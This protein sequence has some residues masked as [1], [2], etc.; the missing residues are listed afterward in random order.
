MGAINSMRPFLPL[1]DGLTGPSPI[2]GIVEIMALFHYYFLII[3]SFIIIL[4]ILCS[5]CQSTFHCILLYIWQYIIII[6]II[7]IMN[8]TVFNVFGMLW[9]F[10]GFVFAVLERYIA[11][12][13]P[14][15]IRWC[16]P[17]TCANQRHMDTWYRPLQLVSYLT[18]KWSCLWVYPLISGIFIHIYLVF[19]LG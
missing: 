13:G 18:A 17:C 12:M 5:H 1:G 2:L 16:R 3:I 11:E 8:S 7:I 15:W 14:E 6:I 4:P 10:D 9:C 19:P